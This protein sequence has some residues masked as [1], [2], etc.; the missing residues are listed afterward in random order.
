K[1]RQASNMPRILASSHMTGECRRVEKNALYSLILEGSA[2]RHGIPALWTRGPELDLH[3]ADRACGGEGQHRGHR[4][5]V[6][7]D[8]QEPLPSHTGRHAVS[9][10]CHHMTLRL[11]PLN[12]GGLLVRQYFSLEII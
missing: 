2:A 8:R 6:M 11:K 4:E 7:A 12:Y 1:R 5:P 9:C 10:H 3:G